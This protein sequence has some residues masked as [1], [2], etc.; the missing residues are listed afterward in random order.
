MYPLD[1]SEFEKK[2]LHPFKDKSLLQQA[3]IHRSYIN[4]AEE[5]NGWGDNERLEFLGDAVLGFVVSEL[6]YKEYP[7]YQEGEL[8]SLRS[9]LV[10]QRM[11]AKLARQYRMGDFL[12]LG[13]GE[14]S[15]GGRE[16]PVTLCATFEAVVGAIYLDQGIESVREFLLSVLSDELASSQSLTKD[17]KSRLQEWIQGDLGKPPRY[18]TAKQEGPDHAT[19]FTIQVKVDGIVCGVGQGLSKQLASQAAAA[20]AL[21]YLGGDAPEFE[22]NPELEAEWPVN[23]LP[24]VELIEQGIVSKKI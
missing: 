12:W 5:Q 17:A 14:E 10:R 24:L 11:L 20:M 18:H 15:S 7:D 21:H 16:R 6:I 9:T 1:V 13:H 23:Q 4:E 22:A 2:L 8:T 19:T 3:F